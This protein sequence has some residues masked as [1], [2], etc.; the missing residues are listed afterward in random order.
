MTKVN[1][2]RFFNDIVNEKTIKDLEN[3]YKS[4]Y[5]Y[6][7][8]YC[9]DLKNRKDAPNFDIGAAELAYFVLYACK[10]VFEINHITHL[11]ASH[12]ARICRKVKKRVFEINKLCCEENLA[13]CDIFY[14][15][16]MLIFMHIMRVCDTNFWN[17][18]RRTYYDLVGIDHHLES[19]SAFLTKDL[20]EEFSLLLMEELPY[21]FIHLRVIEEYIYEDSFYRRIKEKQKGVANISWDGILSSINKDNINDKT[22]ADFLNTYLTTLLNKEIHDTALYVDCAKSLSTKI[23]AVKSSLE[24][25]PKVVHTKEYNEQKNVGTQT[26]DVQSGGIGAQVQK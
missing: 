18:A 16:T 3:Y 10:Q 2:F 19:F 11:H 12:I 13:A 14:I 20:K 17:H 9:S 5:K 15:T 7:V 23:G 6:I 22:T 8:N 24:Q 25:A 26:G 21:N 1:K 4:I